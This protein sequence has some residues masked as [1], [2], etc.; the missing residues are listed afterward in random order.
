MPCVCSEEYHDSYYVNYKDAE[1]LCCQAQWLAH[2][3]GSLLEKN[4]IILPDNLSKLLRKHRAMLKKHKLDELDK[5]IIEAKSE[6]KRIESKIKQ[7]RGLGGE[8]TPETLKL[9][10]EAKEKLETLEKTDRLL[11]LG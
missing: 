10:S 8:P 3:L 1:E 7:I 4:G 5:D 6:I 2:S 9:F 11:I